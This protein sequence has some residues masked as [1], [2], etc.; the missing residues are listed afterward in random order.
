MNSTSHAW[1]AQNLWPFD[2]RAQPGTV[3]GDEHGVAC[4][5]LSLHRLFTTR[6]FQAADVEAP[7][8]F[9]LSRSFGKLGKGPRGSLLSIFTYLHSGQ[10]STLRWQVSSSVKALISVC[11]G[12]CSQEVSI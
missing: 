1:L 10:S 7:T 8:R 4:F 5:M 11:S 6:G 3:A 9:L 2:F 12:Q